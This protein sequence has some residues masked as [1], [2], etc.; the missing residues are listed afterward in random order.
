MHIVVTSNESKF[1]KWITH[2]SESHQCDIVPEQSL[3]NETV[4]A[5]S[6]DLVLYTKKHR[7][8]YENQMTFY[9]VYT[10]GHVHSG[11]HGWT[12]EQHNR[13]TYGWT[14]GQSDHLSEPLTV[15]Y[16]T[17]KTQTDRCGI[18][19]WKVANTFSIAFIY[20]NNNLTNITCTVLDSNKLH[21]N[22]SLQNQSNGGY[23]QDMFY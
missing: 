16:T 2:S 1:V 3:L 12:V 6:V 11:I 8:I 19:T 9:S 13:W 5:V 14:D 18:Y 17:W 22:P 15:I 4:T 23:L 7:N 10:W 21:M 20:V